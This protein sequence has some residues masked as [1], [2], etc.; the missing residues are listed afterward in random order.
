MK[1]K[2]EWKK[3]TKKIFASW[4]FLHPDMYFGTIAPREWFSCR[5]YG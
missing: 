2:Q 3:K 1:T 5:F 4:N